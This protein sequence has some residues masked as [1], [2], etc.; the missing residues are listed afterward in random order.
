VWGTQIAFA[1]PERLPDLP[2]VAD[3]RSDIEQR[4]M[5]SRLDVAGAKQNAES[6]AANLGLSKATRFVNVMELGV[7]RETSNEAPTRRGYEVLL[8][9][10]L[11]D[12][13]TSRIAKAEALYMQALDRA[14][15]TAINARSEVRESYQSYRVTFDI[16]KH[17]RDEIVPIRK[18]IAD[19]NLLRYNGMLIGVFDLLS[20]ARSQIGS[21][22]SYIEALRDFWLAESDLQMAMLGRPIAGDM[23]RS[24]MTTESAA[25]GH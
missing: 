21:V 9:L 22:N 1:L 4:A 7:S 20:D 8:E 11:F 10:P 14:A 6:L 16:A 13:G 23:T 12:W 25:A 24:M 17:Y 18:R 15:E 3:E 2:V 5:Q 19:E